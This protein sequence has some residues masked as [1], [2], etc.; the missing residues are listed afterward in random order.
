M[1]WK[2]SWFLNPAF[3]LILKLALKNWVNFSDSNN[4]FL[5]PPHSFPQQSELFY[6][7]PQNSFIT[8]HHN[9]YHKNILF[10]PSQF[11]SSCLNLHHHLSTMTVIMNC[12][13]ASCYFFYLCAN[14]FFLLLSGESIIF[15]ISHCVVVDIRKN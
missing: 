7:Y 1:C 14:C 15:I 6:M 2:L 10:F 12:F 8:T 9:L 13:V 4:I 3:M 11:L 5:G